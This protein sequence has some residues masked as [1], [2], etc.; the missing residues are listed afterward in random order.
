[1]LHAFEQ[2]R[3]D[4]RWMQAGMNNALVYD[5]APIDPVAQQMEQSAPAEGLATAIAVLV[6]TLS[7]RTEPPQ[8]RFLVKHLKGS[9]SY[10]HCR[11]FTY[12]T[13]PSMFTK[14]RYYRPM[15]SLKPRELRRTVILKAQMRV[16]DGWRAVTIC[17]V[18]SRGLMAKCS[19]PPAKGA[20]IEL[21]HRGVHI[22]G[23]VAW[24]QGLR[25]GV[26][27]QDNIDIASLLDQSPLNGIRTR[28][29]IW[30]VIP[31]AEYVTALAA[32]DHFHARPRFFYWDACPQSLNDSD[33]STQTQQQPATYGN[34][35]AWLS[36]PW[37]AQHQISSNGVV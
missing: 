37:Y 2:A 12:L 31:E 15:A 9:R 19:A 33:R 1:L 8:A 25:F 26:R 6:Q 34:S 30:T 27:A 4:D 24:S 20:Y 28:G 5:L 35:T 21:R 16:A 3:I 14:H 17:N 36:R 23:R 11:G 32:F 29:A 22:V 10:N 18:S 7:V 13:T